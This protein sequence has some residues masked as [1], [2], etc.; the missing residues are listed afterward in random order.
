M[1]RLATP[2]DVVLGATEIDYMLLDRLAE[3][4][5]GSKFEE[6][7]VLTVIN[8]NQLLRLKRANLVIPDL[9]PFEKR[10]PRKGL[11]L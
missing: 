2:S 8:E 4:F 7:D 6:E 1:L 3:A 5:G 11:I 10:F 9:E